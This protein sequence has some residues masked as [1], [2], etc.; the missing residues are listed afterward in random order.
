M[1]DGNYP[2]YGGAGQR[3]ESQ[4]L[5]HSTPLFPPSVHIGFAEVYQILKRSIPDTE[6]VGEVRHIELVIGSLSDTAVLERVSQT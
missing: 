2:E 1:S 6:L 4:G 5:F 3:H